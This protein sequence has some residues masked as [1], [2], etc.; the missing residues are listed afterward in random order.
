MNSFL[1]SPCIFLIYIVAL[2]NL[3]LILCAFYCNLVV[4]D[5]IIL[6]TQ[7]HEYWNRMFY[8]TTHNCIF[9]LMSNYLERKRR[10]VTTWNIF[11]VCTKFWSVVSYIL[12]KCACLGICFSTCNAT[13][14]SN[15]H[16]LR[17]SK[18]N[19]I[20]EDTWSVW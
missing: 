11:F 4:F 2:S 14:M 6:L 16:T 8:T 1:C 12:W 20:F 18:F 7:P 9:F 5:L 10:Q 3:I 15:N 19:V 17:H 13:S